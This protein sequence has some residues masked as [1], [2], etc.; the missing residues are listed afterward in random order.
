LQIRLT[1]EN[2]NIAIDIEIQDVN[3]HA[4]VFNHEVYETTIDESTPQGTDTQN[5]FKP[6]GLLA[7]HFP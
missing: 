3:D 1:N 5:V 4:P 6:T 7:A 2:T